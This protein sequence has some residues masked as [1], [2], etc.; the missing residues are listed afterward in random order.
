MEKMTIHRALAELKTLDKR[1]DSKTESLKPV[2]FNVDGG[3]V[4]KRYEL[5]EFAKQV[6][7]DLQ[8][9]NDL[10]LRKV[11]LKS[12]IVKANSETLVNIAGKEMTISDAISYKQVL[13][14]KKLLKNS[15]EVELL[16]TLTIIEKANA[17]VESNALKI[18]ENALQKDNVKIT[19][20]D[21]L[22][23]TEPYL[24]KNLCELVDPLKIEVKI[25]ELQEDID[26]FELE[27]DATLSEINATT[28]IE[29]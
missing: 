8:S 17:T 23:V 3:K 16:K 25:K 29:I 7:S 2:G 26:S 4:N 1:I 11:R 22:N 14:M 18:A 5:S 12:A 6:S 28:Y 20:K 27:V 15:L 10:I 21:V 13:N 19:D 24:K 9:I